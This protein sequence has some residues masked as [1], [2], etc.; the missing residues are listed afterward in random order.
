MN[1]TIDLCSILIL[2]SIQG[3]VFGLIL[4]IWYRISKT[5]QCLWLNYQALKWQAMSY[6]IPVAYI[7]NRDIFL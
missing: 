4:R 5:E 6:L 1:W 3:M 2:N 7:L